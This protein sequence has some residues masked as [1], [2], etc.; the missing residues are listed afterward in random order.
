MPAHATMASRVPVDLSK[1]PADPWFFVSYARGTDLDADVQR[2]RAD[3]ANRLIQIAGIDDLNVANVGYLDTGLEPGDYWPQ[4]LSAKLHAARVL[5]PLYSPRYFRRTYCGKE[6]QL[7]FQPGRPILPVLLYPIL[8]EQWPADPRIRD[9]QAWSAQYPKSYLDHGLKHILETPGF[10]ADYRTL[11]RMFADRLRVLAHQAPE[12][13]ALGVLPDLRTA[14][15]AFAAGNPAAATVAE[16]ANM[17]LVRFV[18]AAAKKA[19]LNR[20]SGGYGDLGGIDWAPF[21]PGDG[22][23]INVIAISAADRE[24]FS[25]DSSVPL[26]GMTGAFLTESEARRAILV[27]L[28]D[29]WSLTLPQYRALMACCDAVKPGRAF[30]VVWNG[31]DGESMRRAAELKAAVAQALPTVAVAVRHPVFFRDQVDTRA[32]LEAEIQSV[33]MEIHMRAIQA[34]TAAMGLTAAPPPVVA[35][36]QSQGAAGA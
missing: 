4:Q 32:A 3:V 8:E 36:S 6:F 33:L 20:A 12:P 35:N 13:S 25:C 28:V 26:D 14:P 10:E 17:R 7:F 27:I 5:M 24:G 11:I 19:E 18:C 31:G 1:V 30:I 9:L 16:P 21:S 22:T 23:R 29:P 34:K 2:F 15:S